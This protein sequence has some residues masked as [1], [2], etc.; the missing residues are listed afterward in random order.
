MAEPVTPPPVEVAGLIIPADMAAEIIAAF[1]AL[2]PTITDGL[3]DDA[4]VRAVLIW[5]ITSSLQSYYGRQSSRAME[6]TIEQIRGQYA[7]RAR[8]L[9]ERVRAA[10]ATIKEKP[11]A[12][13]PGGDGYTEV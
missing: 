2:Y 13:A 1:R 4:A 5:M 8:E 10:A 9:E 12:V 6:K 3:D 11:A 7:V